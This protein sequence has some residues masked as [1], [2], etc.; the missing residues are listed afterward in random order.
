M[1][2]TVELIYDADCPNVAAARSQLLRSFA[3][4]GVTPRWLEWER[5]TKTGPAY[6]RDY[7]S[8]TI[9]VNRRDV[10]ITQPAANNHCRI[11]YNHEGRLRGTPNVEDI[12]RALKNNRSSDG[13][14]SGW[15]NFAPT[16]PA[17]GFA[18]LPKLTCPACWPAYAGL[19]SALGLGFVD[20][21]PYLLPLTALFLAAT[22]GSLGYRAKRRRG[23]GPLWV[24]VAAS[25]IM[26]AGKFW[27][28][29]NPALYSG[30]ALLVAASL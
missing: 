21:T 14:G 3:L 12:A 5:N 19:L 1:N 22:L 17:V 30:I 2:P 16:A 10:S 6:V 9:L 26:I 29:S 8:P 23:Y 24:G 4:T 27:F 13:A 7:G 18:L 11:Y 25:V 15:R 28:D 20:Y